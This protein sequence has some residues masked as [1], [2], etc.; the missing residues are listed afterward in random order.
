MAHALCEY[1]ISLNYENNP[2]R[3]IIILISQVRKTEVQRSQVTC[4][5]AHIPL[6]KFQSWDSNSSVLTSCFDVSKDHTVLA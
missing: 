5:R 3:A 4:L 1:N 2:T 6:R